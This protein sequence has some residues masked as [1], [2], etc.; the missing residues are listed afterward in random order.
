MEQLHSH[1]KISF[2]MI[3]FALLLIATLLNADHGYS[4]R[5]RS[6]RRGTFISFLRKKFSISFS[7][8]SQALDCRHD[9]LMFL[10]NWF[11]TRKQVHCC[12]CVVL[13]FVFFRLL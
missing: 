13:Y 3:K 11:S 8:S 12:L 9:L 1:P 6:Y 10:I 7:I 2:K 4:L 5:S